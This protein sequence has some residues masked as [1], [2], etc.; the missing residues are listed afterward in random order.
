MD[1]ICN[2]KCV[3]TTII[4]ARNRCDPI[5]PS[6]RIFAKN[7]PFVH[8]QV[9]AQRTVGN[10]RPRRPEQQVRLLETGGSDRY[11]RRYRRDRP[12]QLGDR[13]RGSQLSLPVAL[14]PAIQHLPVP[15][16][17]VGLAF[18]DAVD[19]PALILGEAE[20]LAEPVALTVDEEGLDPVADNVAASRRQ[21][22]AGGAGPCAASASGLRG[23]AH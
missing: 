17:T 23:S 16:P 22:A 9:V 21:A 7:L 20:R 18:I 8:L 2:S 14:R 13:D 1:L 10:H 12:R 4:C 15:P 6:R 3:A 5:D 11:V 19:E